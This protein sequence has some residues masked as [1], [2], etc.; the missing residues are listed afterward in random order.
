MAVAKPSL[1]IL[2]NKAR[3]GRRTERSF[4]MCTTRKLPDVRLD[5]L[6]AVHLLALPSRFGLLQ[7][8]FRRWTSTPI[9]SYLQHCN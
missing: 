7:I 4:G 2:I 6:Q 8:L 1:S 3:Q 5:M 9:K